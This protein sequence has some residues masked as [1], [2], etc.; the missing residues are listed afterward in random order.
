VVGSGCVLEGEAGCDGCST[1]TGEVLGSVYFSEFFVEFFLCQ[2]AA[3][4]PFLHQ[5]FYFF[6]VLWDVALGFVFAG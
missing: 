5:F 4:E 6:Q 3:F 2:V 1:E